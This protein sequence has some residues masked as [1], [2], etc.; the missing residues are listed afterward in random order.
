MP[1]HTITITTGS[2]DLQ[3]QDAHD[4]VW[5]IG[6]APDSW[7]FTPDLDAAAVRLAE[8]WLITQAIAAWLY[9]QSALTGAPI[10]GCASTPDT[11]TTNAYGPF[12]NA[13]GTV[14]PH[15]TCGTPAA[16]PYTSTTR[17]APAPPAMGQLSGNS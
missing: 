1:R 12:S 10:A 11:Q 4:F 13:N 9:H 8:P 15:I 2:G 17:T 3:V 16:G 5:R 7:A 6:F 14:K